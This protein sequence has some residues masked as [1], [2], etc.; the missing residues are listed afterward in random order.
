MG[1]LALLLGVLLG[2]GGLV[3]GALLGAWLAAAW[4]V[5]GR[6]GLALF[7]AL[8]VPDWK[9]FVRLHVGRDGAL[10]LHAVGVSRV[11]RRWRFVPNAP[12]G[13]PWFE[14]AD[15]PIVDRAE[16]VEPPVRIPPPPPLSN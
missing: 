3:G 4:V 13:R 2:A 7:A 16:L 8:G 1:Q 12:P 14:P 10:T 9:S 5:A 6:H 11:A 15:G